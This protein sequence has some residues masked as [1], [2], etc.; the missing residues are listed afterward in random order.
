MPRPVTT[1]VRR[2]LGRGDGRASHFA[3]TPRR[4]D[5][6]PE[7]RVAQVPQPILDRIGAD[8]G[9]DLVHEALVRERVLQP[10]RRAQR[11]GEERRRTR[12]VSTR[13]LLHDA[14]AA[15][16]G[17]DAPGDVGR[18]GVGAVVEPPGGGGAGV[19]G[20]NGCGWNAGEQAG[21]DVA[22]RVVAG[23]AAQRR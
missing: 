22:R 20:A 14:A 23:P 13:S 3:A 18:R 21:D 19:R 2:P 15:A 12:C 16:L 8:R 5:D 4:L 7:T 10:L 6:G 9:R 1:P 11:T 17:A